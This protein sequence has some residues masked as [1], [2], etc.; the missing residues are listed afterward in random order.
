MTAAPSAAPES[1]MLLARLREL[2]PDL[3][4]RHPVASLAIFDS[5]PVLERNR[6][7][8]ATY[9]ALG[10]AEYEAIEGFVQ[11]RGDSKA[12]W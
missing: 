6:A 10:L 11:W 4:H 1:V 2:L 3:R 12:L 5:E 8:A 7:T 9:D